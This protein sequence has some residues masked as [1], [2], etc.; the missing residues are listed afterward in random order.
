MQKRIKNVITFFLQYFVCSPYNFTLDCAMC[1]TKK[2]TIR[3][4]SPRNQQHCTLC[5]IWIVSMSN[6][7]KYEPHKRNEYEHMLEL[8][9]LYPDTYYIKNGEVCKKVMSEKEME[10]FNLQNAKYFN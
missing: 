2:T 5:N 1:D 7:V 3:N 9:K 4:S 10:L 6:H 8:V